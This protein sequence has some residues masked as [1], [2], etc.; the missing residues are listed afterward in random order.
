MS[1]I[2]GEMM[3]EY[4]Q[5]DQF[6]MSVF[7]DPKVAKVINNCYRQK[8]IRLHFFIGDNKTGE[9]WLEEYDVTGSIGRSTGTNKIP[10]LLNNK[11][12]LRGHSILTENVVKIMYGY[13]VLYQHENYHIAHLEIQQSDE[14]FWVLANG[15]NHAR[16]EKEKNA[17]N[18]IL[19]L[20]GERGFK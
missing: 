16:F 3:A 20:L 11:H 19:F 15:K 10:L 18:F 5:F 2:K 4:K 6:W 7:T 1:E 13:K 12:S 8:N 14:H 17:N 9:D